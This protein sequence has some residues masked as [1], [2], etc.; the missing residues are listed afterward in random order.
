MILLRLQTNYLIQIIPPDIG[1]TATPCTSVQMHLSRDSVSTAGE[2][3]GRTLLDV[4]A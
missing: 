1:T 4:D 2:P 3:E